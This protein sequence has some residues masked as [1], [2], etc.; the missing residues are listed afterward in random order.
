MIFMSGKKYQELKDQLE[1]A[2][3]CVK[4]REAQMGK[5][6]LLRIIDKECI[7]ALLDLIQVELG[8]FEKS[9]VDQTLNQ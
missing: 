8:P 7:R 5:L 6:E 3:S 2:N 1:G 4:I 9:L